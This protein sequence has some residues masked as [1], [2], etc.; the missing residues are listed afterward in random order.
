[1]SKAYLYWRE[2]FAWYPVKVHGSWVWLR[3]V[4]RRVSH[5]TLDWEYTFR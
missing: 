2:W 4:A 1:M 3:P 5:T